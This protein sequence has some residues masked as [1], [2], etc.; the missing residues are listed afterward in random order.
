MTVK[1]LIIRFS[2]IGDIVLTTPV[3]RNIKQQMNEGD[4]VVHFLSKNQF[5][6]ILENNPYI[7][8][9]HLIDENVAP[10]LDDL[11]EERFDYIFD[12]HR[13]LRSS[14]VKRGLGIMDF[15][16]KKYNVQKWILVNLKVNKMPDMHIVDRYMETTKAFNIENDNKGL[17]YFI[18]S[19]DEVSLSV[20]P[21]EFSNGYIAFAI[22]GQHEGKMLPN[23][24]IIEICNG[25]KTPVIL[26]G[27]K[28]DVANGD[29]IAAKSTNHVFNSCG[30]FSLNQSASILHQSQTVITH[31]TGL[32]HIASALKKKVISIWGATVPEF[33]MYPYFPGE[34]SKIIE[35]KG[36][37][38]PYSKLGN[39]QWYKAAFTG[40]EKIDVAE[41]LEA[42]GEFDATE[43]EMSSKANMD[44]LNSAIDEFKNGNGFTK[45][46]IED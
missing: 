22:G 6:G 8:K 45:E 20:F 39:K 24:K 43:H 26:L 31:D 18:P 44:R 25:L 3:I 29:E 33:G 1:V 9:L 37:S 7:D 42:V 46:I 28:E 12:L 36:V 21:P 10:I 34:G 35:P 11:K 4:V 15:T 40:M 13:N 14:Q 17:D 27:G 2:S 38:R 23:H 32:M 19:E 5:K 16:F 41:V 30:K